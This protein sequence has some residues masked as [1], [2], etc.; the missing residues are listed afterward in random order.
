MADRKKGE[1][2]VAIT[3][4]LQWITSEEQRKRGKAWGSNMP[5]SVMAAHI[6][7]LLGIKR[8]I[9]KGFKFK[10]VKLEENSQ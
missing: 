2:V 1:I 7:S 3:P 4:E 10:I 8:S 9:T 6:A 5:I